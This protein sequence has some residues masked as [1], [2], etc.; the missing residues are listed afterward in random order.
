MKILV[1]N[2]PNINMLGVREP[3]L[4]GSITLGEIESKIKDAA[5]TS[6][7]VSFFQSNHE[8]AM[9]DRIHRAYD[10][11]IDYIIINAGAY[12]HTS[13]A[14]RDAFLATEIP[15]IEV[16]L[17]NVFAREHY[18]SES[19]LADIAIGVISGFRE[20]SYILALAHLLSQ[21]VKIKSKK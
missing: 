4:Y 2:G 17:S 11:K 9:V 19:Y 5:G 8:G 3:N 6:A 21:D 20:N 7:S 15:F 1:M 13:I 18:R 10:E 14:L 16:H 12:S